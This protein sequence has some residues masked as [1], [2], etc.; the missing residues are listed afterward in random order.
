V[1]GLRHIGELTLA[2]TAGTLSEALI[3]SMAAGLLDEYTVTSL[4][5]DTPLGRYMA[6]EFG[7]VRREIG[8]EYPWRIARKRVTLTEL[9]TTPAFG[10]LAQYQLPSDCLRVY[11]LTEDG[12]HN[13][14]PVKF[15]IEGT[16]LLCDMQSA[17]Y[18]IYVRDETNVA[19]WTALM[20]RTFAA[21]MAMYASQN[22]TGK[23]GYFDKCQKA[24]TNASIQART[25]DALA[26]GSEETTYDNGYDGFDT[27]SSRGMY[28]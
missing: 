27:M 26:E 11:R 3:A 20:G 4:D 10:F 7:T 6:R 2:N 12:T 1:G 23:A 13:G 24:Y 19:L 17:V 22:V 9:G 16:K 25:S 8:E 14:K 5:D 28:R 15:K 18:L 21:K